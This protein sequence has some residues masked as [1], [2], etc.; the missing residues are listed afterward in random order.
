MCRI[1]SCIAKNLDLFGKEPKLYYKKEEQFNTTLGIIISFAYYI[2][3]IALFTYKF[4]KM[5]NHSDVTAYDTSKYISYKPSIKLSNNI[6]YGGFALQNPETYD[7]FIDESI[8][9][10]KAYYKKAVRKGG[11]NTWHWENKPIELEI[12]N[13]SKFGKDFK[14]IFKKNTLNNLYCFNKY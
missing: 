1:F 4:F 6:F 2:L 3:Y 10:P 12:C 13:L 7:S 5:T 14:E 11:N 8:Y 9:Y